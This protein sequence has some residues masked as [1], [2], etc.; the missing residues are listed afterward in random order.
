MAWRCHCFIF[1][2]NFGTDL[3]GQRRVGRNR[4]SLSR[5]CWR[6]VCNFQTVR[7]PC[8]VSSA[9]PPAN[10]FFQGQ[11]IETRGDYLSERKNRTVKRAKD[12]GIQSTETVSK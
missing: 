8:G 5:L 2:G 9:L 4:R 6:G 10:D 3:S 12:G 11:R 7:K 1:F